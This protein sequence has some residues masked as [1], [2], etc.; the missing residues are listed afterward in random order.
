MKKTSLF[1]LLIIVSFL[2][3]SAQQQ[4]GI[5]GGRNGSLSYRVFMEVDQAYEVKLVGRNNGLQFTVLNERFKPTLMKWSQNLFLY[6]GLGLHAGFSSSEQNFDEHDDKYT[7]NRTG[8]LAGVDF[9][10]GLEY[11]VDK[12]PI[13]VSLDINPYAEVSASDFFRLNI[14]NSGFS[15]R[16]TFK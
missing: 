6:T 5:R 7:Y 2:T 9:V 4:V 11:R 1:L 15:V 3:A 14:W 10:C 12:Y 13:T 16:Y 8:P